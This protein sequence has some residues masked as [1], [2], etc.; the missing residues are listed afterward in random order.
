[1]PKPVEIAD[2]AMTLASSFLAEATKEIIAM[3]EG[4]MSVLYEAAQ[5]VKSRATGPASEHSAEHLAFSLL[6]AA[7][8]ELRA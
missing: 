6:T 2:R 8:A 5:D 7:H 1:M 3:S 4:D